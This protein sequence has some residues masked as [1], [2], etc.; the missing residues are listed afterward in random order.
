[1]LA[2]IMTK[3]QITFLVKHN[4]IAEPDF[5]CSWNPFKFIQK[6]KS[7]KMRVWGIAP[8]YQPSKF[9]GLEGQEQ[10]DIMG[11]E[12]IHY[13]NFFWQLWDNCYI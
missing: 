12:E 2:Q 10:L 13:S 3:A 6:T 1:M 5:V 8:S 9:G 11:T 4:Q 7:Y